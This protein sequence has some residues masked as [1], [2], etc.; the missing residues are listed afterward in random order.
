[1]TTLAAR[2][3]SLEDALQEAEQRYVAANPKSRARHAEAA[4]S[5]PGG[6]TR[7]ILYYPPFPVTIRRGEGARLFDLDGHAYLDFL[8]EY[9]AGLY[10]HSDPVIQSA[11]R[12]ALS[13]GILLGAPNRYEAELA[14]LMCDRFPSVELVRFCNSGTEANLNALMGARALTG[15]SHVMVFEHAYH[16]GMLSFG[17][18]ASPMNIPFDYVFGRFN[19]LDYTTAQIERHGDDLAAIIIE[20]MMGAGGCIA[21]EASF[22][23][24]LREAATRHGIILIF[25]EVMT[26]RLSPGGLQGKLGILPDLTTFG[27]YLGGGMSFGA[28]GGRAE[29]MSRFDPAR[30][31]AIPHSGTYNNNVLTMAAGV[32]GLSKVFTPEAADALS[33]SGERLKARLNGIGERHGA[34][35]QVTGVGSILC[36]HFQSEPIR[37]PADAAHTPAAARALFHLEMLARGFYVARRGF[38]ALSLPLTAADHD[39]FAAAFE[40]LLEAYGPVLRG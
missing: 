15:R 17:Q 9:T 5:L 3:M 16:G 22:L 37:Q 38:L 26:S 8:G 20:P 1:M 25:D 28:F 7:S 21:G 6:N 10:G 24:G 4:R 34:P 27:K 18:S 30:P 36:M 19:D 33:A 31:D 12:E 2:N 23:Q 14:R 35:V 13:D 11:V 32:A 29:L 40:D 39:A